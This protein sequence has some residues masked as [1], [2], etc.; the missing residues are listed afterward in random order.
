[1][2]HQE[3][4]A[5]NWWPLPAELLPRPL[6]K[7]VIIENITAFIAYHEGCECDR[8]ERTPLNCWNCSGRDKV[9]KLSDIVAFV[10]SY[11]GP[12]NT[13]GHIATTFA[14]AIEREFSGDG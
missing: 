12:I 2:E 1:M 9:V 7:P 6:R 11:T 13:Q 10:S 14:D 4:R 3:Q 5:E 8:N